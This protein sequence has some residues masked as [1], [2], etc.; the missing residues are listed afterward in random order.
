MMFDS[1]EFPEPLDEMLF[2]SWLDDGRQSKMGY[3]YLLIVWNELERKYQPVY[4]EERAKIQEY[5]RY[6][7]VTG[8]EGLI[9]AYDL[10][11]ESRIV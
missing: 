7:G 3:H 5:E 1:S 10:Y 2:D 8:R 9:A 6:P 4:L 11:S